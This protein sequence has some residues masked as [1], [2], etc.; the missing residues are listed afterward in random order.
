MTSNAPSE[1]IPI[2]ENST[3]SFDSTVLLSVDNGKSVCSASLINNTKN[4]GRKLI[5]TAA[6]C[7]TSD[8]RYNTHY[9]VL[10][11]YEHAT[12]QPGQSEP[13]PYIARGINVLLNDEHTDTAIVELI[14]EIPPGSQI[15]YAGWTRE[16]EVPKNAVSIHHP[17]GD[18]KMFAATRG[19]HLSLNEDAWGRIVLDVKYWD[20]GVVENGSSGS[21]L[22]GE[23]GLIRGHLIG[24]QGT[25]ETN[26][27][28]GFLDERKRS[29]RTM[30]DTKGKK[31]VPDMFRAF[32]NA[33]DILPEMRMILDPIGKRPMKLEALII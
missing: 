1:P 6:H 25:C 7:L 23:D 33:W 11:N 24:G 32:F 2:S 22:F 18:V 8:K 21:P 28:I 10:F 16:T 3:I 19:Q 12:C 17:W 13:K 14:G 9:T 31:L 15:Q 26:A 27:H 30:R 5:L 29:R 20:R 4:D